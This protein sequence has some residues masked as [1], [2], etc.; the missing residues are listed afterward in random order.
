MAAGLQPY[1]VDH[2]YHTLREWE[3]RFLGG[4]A[5]QARRNP[6]NLNIFDEND[7]AKLDDM[8]DVANKLWGRI[9]GRRR[10]RAEFES[11][12]FEKYRSE[13]VC[14]LTLL[15]VAFRNMGLIF[16]LWKLNANTSTH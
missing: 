15:P 5:Y 3:K 2:P 6:G 13:F 12:F 16:A 1:A 9:N 11:D 7:P 4:P 14:R 8:H 10:G